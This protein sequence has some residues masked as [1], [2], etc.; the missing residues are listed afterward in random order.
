MILRFVLDRRSGNERT[1]DVSAQSV[2]LVPTVAI[3]FIGGAIVGITSVGAGSL[4][5]VMLMFLY[6]ALAAKRLVGTDL[7]QAIPLTAAAAL[8]AL[9]FGHVEFTV[10]AAIILGSVPAVFIGSLLSSR[11]PDKQLRPIITLVII[12]SGLKYVGLSPTALGVS[13]G[14]VVLAGAC[15]WLA[16]SASGRRGAVG[17]PEIKEPAL[18]A[19]VASGPALE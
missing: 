18:A 19:Q 3:G 2:K 4:M 13:M 5:I 16:W 10:T 15:G 17:G 11:F 7:A 9:A 8:G 12:A 6:P 14:V 1:G